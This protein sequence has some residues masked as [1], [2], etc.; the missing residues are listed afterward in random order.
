MIEETEFEDTGHLLATTL[1]TDLPSDVESRLR[2]R[3]EELK[4]KIESTSL[5]DVVPDTKQRRWSMRPK[6]LTAISAAILLCAVVLFP[7]GSSQALAQIAKA[8]AATKWL[9]ASGTGPHGEP[10][11][12]WFSALN[13]ILASRTNDSFL[14]VDQRLGKMDV[15]GKP[16][17]ID[18]IQRTSLNRTEIKGIQASQ[19][20]LLAMLTGDLQRAM[21]AGEMQVLEHEETPIVVDGQPMIEHRFVAGPK[22]NEKVRIET[23]LQV[24][25]KT[26]LP[27]TWRIKSGGQ[28][29]G[30]FKV[31]YPDHGPLSI[32]GLGASA[33]VP[34]VDQTPRGQFKDVLVATD[35]A[36]SRF[37]NYHAVV[38]ESDVSDRAGNG[39]YYRI[40]RK[41]DRWRIDHGHGLFYKHEQPPEG[42]NPEIWWLQMARK[43]R[44]YPYEIWDG[45]RLWNFETNQNLHQ[46]DPVDP[47]AIRIESLKAMSG[48]PRDPT[49]PVMHFGARVK[50]PERWA[51][52][53]LHRGENLGFRADTIEAKLDGISMT[54]VD[55]RESFGASPKSLVSR[56]WLDPSRDSMEVRKEWFPISQPDQVRSS[57][58]FTAARTPQGLWYPTTLRDINAAISI[59]TGVRS[60]RYTH[61]YLEFDVDMPDELFS[62]EGVDLKNFWT[63]FK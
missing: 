54:R 25:P 29:V 56:Y 62:G 63:Q 14:F 18:S 28:V 49:D 15:Y 31:S 34:I 48:A 13:G 7:F 4:K 1:T 60:D 19:R 58:V 39:T 57:E 42:A 35:T 53:S 45:K 40:W 10:T 3:L 46:E 12:M 20:S 38:I 27:T 30:D 61:Y 6:V 41:G 24:D 21:K 47:H 33:A 26:G 9:H 16:F 55:I 17:S 51:Y 50:L 11:E 8:I 36:R 43:K 22:G 37:D 59:E 52:E 5:A 2:S 23:L 44:S 32:V